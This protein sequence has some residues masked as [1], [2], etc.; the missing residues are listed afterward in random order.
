MLSIA[1][2]F[3]DEQRLL[4]RV[5]IVLLGLEALLVLYGAVSAVVR[6]VVAIR[7]RRP[8]GLRRA[9]NNYGRPRHVRI[10]LPITAFEYEYEDDG[11][12]DMDMDMDGAIGIGQDHYLD[13]VYYATEKFHTPTRPR[14]PA[15][16][17][18]SPSSKV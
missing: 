12:S 2:L 14:A 17:F 18:H 4:N 6:G 9:G 16:L 10:E 7:R 3:D 5:W 11:R 13:D 1:T 15:R 8:G